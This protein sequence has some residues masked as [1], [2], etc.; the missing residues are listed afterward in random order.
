ME[1]QTTKIKATAM[2]LTFY[3]PNFDALKRAIKTGEQL[4]PDSLAKYRDYYEKALQWF[5]QIPELQ[6][7]LGFIYYHLGEK[8]K[9]VDFYQ[10]AIRQD[11]NFFW[12]HY[13][14]GI[15]LYS[16]KQY[17]LAINEFQKALACPF[18]LN[19]RFI[20]DSRIFFQIFWPAPNWEGF[21]VRKSLEGGYHTAQIFLGLSYKMTGHDTEAKK[22]LKG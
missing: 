18:D 11:P 5:P 12:N 9:S 6:G 14:L 19:L 2:Q 21:S 15:I 16:E 22:I 1:R 17:P 3:E 4:T 13:N 20:A 8:Q 7:V 10:R